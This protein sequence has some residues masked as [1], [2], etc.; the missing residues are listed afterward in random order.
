MQEKIFPLAACLVT[1]STERSN[2]NPWHTLH[3]LR[4][5]CAQYRELHPV[6]LG[7]T[8]LPC[9]TT[10]SFLPAPV[11]APGIPG[12]CPAV[13]SSPWATWGSSAPCLA[14]PFFPSSSGH[15]SAA[16]ALSE[17]RVLL[18]LG[19]DRKGDRASP[20]PSTPALPSLS[21]TYCLFLCDTEKFLLCSP[22]P[23]VHPL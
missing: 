13:S 4:A 10:P 2:E 17:P 7:C 23:S 21:C 6:P 5:G 8:Q 16:P 14:Q 19:R 9:S 1:S 20:Y 18:A 22:H 3:S 15:S 11:L 12:Q